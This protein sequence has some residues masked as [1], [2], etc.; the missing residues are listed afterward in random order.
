MIEDKIWDRR[1]ANRNDEGS[2]DIRTINVGIISG[3]WETKPEFT[4]RLKQNGTIGNT[5]NP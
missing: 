1:S 4:K 5:K 2:V 3:I